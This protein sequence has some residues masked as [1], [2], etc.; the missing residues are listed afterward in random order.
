MGLKM[1]IAGALMV[2][3]AGAATAETSEDR[4]HECSAFLVQ[5]AEAEIIRDVAVREG[6]VGVVVDA[7]VW[8]EMPDDARTEM[9]EAVNCWVFEGDDDQSA[10][11]QFLS[12]Q[13]F[14]VMADWGP[15]G[16]ETRR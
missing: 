4:H 6:V 8:N 7:N 5:A 10:H 3:T 9:A 14:A 2:A 13:D 16:L 1:I 11:I 12:H 15:M